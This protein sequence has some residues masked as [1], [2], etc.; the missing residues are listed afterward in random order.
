[1]HVQHVPLGRALLRA[2][3]LEICWPK[4]L[5]PNRTSKS[6]REVVRK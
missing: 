1:M 4:V 5:N 3:H 2:P 6:S